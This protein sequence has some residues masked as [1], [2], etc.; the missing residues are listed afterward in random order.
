MVS[1]KEIVIP[2]L[3]LK[4]GLFH[5][6]KKDIA[7]KSITTQ[8]GQSNENSLYPDLCSFKSSPVK[9][10]LGITFSLYVLY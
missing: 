6:K 2:V 8:G 7:K 10:P 9:A 3:T 5:Y 4:S 1:K